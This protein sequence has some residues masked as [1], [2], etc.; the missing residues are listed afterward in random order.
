M[1][2]SFRSG[3][4]LAPRTHFGSSVAKSGHS[5]CSPSGRSSRARLSA[6][7]GVEELPESLGGHSLN[8]GTTETNEMVDDNRRRQPGRVQTP[9]VA[10][11]GVR[12]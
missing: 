2:R 1:G 8:G 11:R 3:F 6:V 9:H 7:D 4:S 12:R 5:Q 10:E